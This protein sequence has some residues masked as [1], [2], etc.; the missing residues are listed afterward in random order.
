MFHSR[1]HGTGAFVARDIAVRS[2]VIL[3]YEGGLPGRTSDCLAALQV[4]ASETVPNQDPNDLPRMIA[5]TGCHAPD[6]TQCEVMFLG[7]VNFDQRAAAKQLVADIFSPAQ[8]L[9]LTRDRTRKRLL[10]ARGSRPGRL[11]SVEG[12]PT[13][14]LVPD[15]RD[16]CPGTPPLTATDDRGCTNSTLPPGPDR[17]HV[18]DGLG[19]MGIL[20]STTCDGAP[21]PSLSVVRDI[22]LN[23]PNL[24]YLF[25]LERPGNQPD[26]CGLYYEMMTDVVEEFEPEEFF[27]A[28]LAFEKKEAIAQTADT[29]TF[30]LPLVCDPNVETKGDGRSWPCDEVDGDEFDAIVSVRVTN[31][32][33][34]Q[35]VWSGGRQMLFHLCR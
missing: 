26:A 17:Q 7:N 14:N 2:D 28:R 9:W 19:K 21:T 5:A 29:I 4:S 34:L 3:Q 31:G 10:A 12:T 15:D 27:Q 8:Y 30:A 6:S 25:T 35:S 23:R 11:P 24:R 33:G 22:C 20:A 1:A 16:A 13:V 18:H 32:N